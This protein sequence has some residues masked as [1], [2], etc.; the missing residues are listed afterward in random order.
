M[1]NEP[2]RSRNREI[3]TLIQEMVHYRNSLL[4]RADPDVEKVVSLENRYDAILFKAREEYEYDPPGAYFKDGYN[5]YR[6]MEKYRDN[7][8]LFL[9]D[10]KV[11]ATNNEAE[12]HLRNYKRKQ[13]Q[14]VSFRSNESVEAICKGMSC[15]VLMR[16]KDGDNL[17]HQVAEV[18]ESH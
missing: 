18:F 10:T 8:L 2:E 13:A 17:L 5:L 9:H 7:H 1:E 15:L 6:R 16:Q 4:P 3:H 12:R 11:P 14:A